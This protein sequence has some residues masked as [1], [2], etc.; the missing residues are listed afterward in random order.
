MGSTDLKSRK[1]VDGVEKVY[2]DGP[3][4]VFGSL[5][6]TVIQPQGQGD[7]VHGVSDLIFDTNAYAGASVTAANGM[8]SVTT[9]IIASSW[10]EVKLKR[11]LKYRP[12]QGSLGRLTALFDT[13]VA[14][15]YQL[16]GLGNKECGYF[17]GYNGTDFGVLHQETGQVE[18]RA[19]TITTGAGTGTV[20]V[21]LDGSAVTVDIVGGS[22]TTQTAYQLATF[23]DYSQ[24]GD[25]GFTADAVGSVVYFTAKRP[26][27]TSTGTYSV[28]GASIVGTFAQ[29][30]A[31][32]DPTLSFVAQ[33]SMNGDRVDGTGPSGFT[34][35]PQKGNVFQI[36][37]QY[38]GFGNAKIAVEDPVT[39]K[40]ITIHCFKNANARTTPVLKNPNSSVVAGVFNAGNTSAVTL[41]TVS[42][43][44]FIEG[45][46]K[47]LDP[48]FAKSFAISNLNT[49]GAVKPL[50]LFKANSVFNG[51]TSYG[52]FDI[53]RIGGSNQANNQTLTVSLY[54]GAEIGGDVNYEY[55]DQ[56]RSA[57]S[58]ATLA[59]A[60]NTI[61][62][63]S[64]IEPF[65]EFV[66]GGN[67]AIGIPV[68]DLGFVFGQGTP[69][70]VAVRT[71]GL[72]SGRVSV[73]WFEQQ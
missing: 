65:Y 8:C 7:F 42:M 9:G 10:A 20:T 70:L 68:E 59:P 47:K 36:E 66:V 1:T 73:N 13:P 33:S 29:T 14:N 28:S 18:I 38:L 31:G 51:E 43:G 15:N 60:S 12:G 2:V 24:A 37:Y 54:T 32:T 44:G 45:D 5:D 6:V 19:L 23:G 27:S 64:S 26:N 46:V 50:A 69:V 48:K 63:L 35:D 4:G 52:E 57:V 58:I 17:V 72:L 55:V 49:A 67:S 56:T 39:G 41:K 11:G 21:T 53:L 3:S 30:K 25:G 40:F 22:D 61:D 34:I 16:V 62:N 71:S